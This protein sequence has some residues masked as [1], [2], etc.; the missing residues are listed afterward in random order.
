MEKQWGKMAEEDLEV[1]TIAV[2]RTYSRR[3]LLVDPTM[4]SVLSA[5]QGLRDEGT[6]EYAA[7]S[8]QTWPK[9]TTNHYMMATWE[10]TDGVEE[11]E[12]TDE[13]I[14]SEA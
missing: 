14:V 6:P 9:P 1:Q 11:T 5:V 12:E 4:E 2:P 3:V 10:E 7:I 13:G 8:F